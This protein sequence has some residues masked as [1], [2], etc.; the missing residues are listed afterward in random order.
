MLGIKNRHI[1]N[2]GTW[3]TCKMVN[4][5]EWVKNI[6]ELDESFIKSYKE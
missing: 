4:A 3:I 5:L 6:S 1:L 2:I